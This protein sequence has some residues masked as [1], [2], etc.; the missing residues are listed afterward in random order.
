[1][2][3]FEL[4][5]SATGRKILGLG[6]R[7]VKDFGSANVGISYTGTAANGTITDPRFT[8]I[9]G[10]S[11]FAAIINGQI[12][13]DGNTCRFSFSGNVLTWF[14]PYADAGKSWTFPDTTF[15]FGVR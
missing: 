9:L 6:D 12:D 13:P 7:L 11:P 1:M 8:S 15:I 5:D 14:F 2:P 3:S 4:W 10:H